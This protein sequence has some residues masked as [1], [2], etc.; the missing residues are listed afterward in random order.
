PARPE[1]LSVGP[2]REL[3]PGL[4]HPY[5]A[6]TSASANGRVVAVPQGDSTVVLHR[7]RADGPALRRVVLGPQHDGRFSAVSPDGRWVVTCSHWTDG[8]SKSALIWDADTGRKVH[9][10]P[11]EGSTTARFSPDGRWLMTS[12]GFQLWEVGTWRQVRDLAGVSGAAFSPDS[13]LLA[14]GDAI[15]VIRL[16]ETVTGRE[17]ARLTGPEP[18]RYNPA[19]FTP[20]GTRLI[21]GCAGGTALYVWDLRSIR[22]QLKE[23]DLDWEWD[24]FPS[25]AEPVG[26]PAP[27]AAPTIR[28]ITAEAHFERGLA[29][30]KQN[31]LDEAIADYSKAIELDSKLAWAWCNRADAYRELHQYDKAIAD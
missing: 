12:G 31:K 1:V 9:E 14:I 20:D 6:G 30:A 22:R 24:E 17:V 16:V 8:R 11:V 18:V 28:V 27:G 25:A 4:G 29:L 19:C 26:L 7:D 3:A 5:C 2:P 21:A 23:L 10:L 15:S 13:R